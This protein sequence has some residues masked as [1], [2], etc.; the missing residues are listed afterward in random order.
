VTAA[1][2]LPLR[3]QGERL[4]RELEGPAELSLEAL[5]AAS[6]VVLSLLLCWQRAA[7]ARGHSLTFTG[8]SERLRSLAAL[9]RLNAHLPGL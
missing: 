8:A 6:S 1:N 7:H 3:Q 2:V 4:I 5:Q 9:S